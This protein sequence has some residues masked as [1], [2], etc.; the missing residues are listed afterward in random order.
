M[1]DK[2]SLS[3]LSV[4]AIVAI[5]QPMERATCLE[6]QKTRSVVIHSSET[7]PV[8]LPGLAVFP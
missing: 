2:I 5:D 3:C 1:L 4:A 6:A 8:D 7:E